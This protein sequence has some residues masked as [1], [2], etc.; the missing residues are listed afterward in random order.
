V[1]KE[2]H[3]SRAASDWGGRRGLGILWAGGLQKA[4]SSWSHSAAVGKMRRLFDRQE[5]VYAMLSK[6]D[7]HKS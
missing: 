6:A 2:K 7:D 3:V 5:I 1:G 4:A